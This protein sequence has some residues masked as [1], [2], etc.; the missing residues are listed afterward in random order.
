MEHLKDSLLGVII[1]AFEKMSVSSF[2]LMIP[3][4]LLLYVCVFVEDDTIE[5]AF[6]IEQRTVPEYVICPTCNDTIK[7]IAH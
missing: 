5:R 4:L 1:N 3:A 7:V 6:G 2:M